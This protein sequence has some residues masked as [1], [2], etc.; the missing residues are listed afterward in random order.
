MYYIYKHRLYSTHLLKLYRNSL[1]Y[2]FVFV[3][4]GFGHLGILNKHISRLRDSENT[5]M[6]IHCL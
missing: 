1:H 6:G 4:Y 2:W 3:L 5:T